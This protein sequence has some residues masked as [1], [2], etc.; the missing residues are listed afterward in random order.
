ML[1]AGGL[2]ERRSPP[3]FPGN[4]FRKIGTYFLAKERMLR[5]GGSV[6]SQRR[7]QTVGLFVSERAIRFA[8]LL[9]N[10]GPGVVDLGEFRRVLIVHRPE[11]GGLR[12]LTESNSRR[13]SCV[14]HRSNGPCAEAQH[15]LVHKCVC[16]RRQRKL[17][18]CA[19][20]VS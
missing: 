5:W 8:I 17:W 3:S 9:D 18:P 10:S 2:T 16:H 1:N 15:W 7:N 19:E 20:E 14:F 13:M 4:T 11:L 6:S 12:C